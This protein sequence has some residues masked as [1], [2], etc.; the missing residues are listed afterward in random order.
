MDSGLVVKYLPGEPDLPALEVVLLLRRCALARGNQQQITQ[1]AVSGAG[2]E[3]RCFLS[4]ALDVAVQEVRVNV[5]K[6][7]NLADEIDTPALI[8]EC[9]LHFNRRVCVD[10]FDQPAATQDDGC[11][12]PVRPEHEQ[13]IENVFFAG[14]E[15]SGQ[16][17]IEAL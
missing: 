9:R 12:V 10:Q 8:G 3:G 14:T 11:E 4:I 1:T 16:Q 13:H 6:T 2:P 15:P 5:F 17:L 7:R